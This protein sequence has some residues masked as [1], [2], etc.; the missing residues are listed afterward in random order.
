LASAYPLIL[1]LSRR[2]VVIIGGGKV[3]VRKAG[4]IVA[5]GGKLIRVIA[6][7]VEETM[8]PEVQVVRESFRPDHLNGA[9]LV[10]AATNDPAVNDAVVL[11]CRQ[12]NLLVCRADVSATLPG[13]FSTP[14]LLRKEDLLVAVSAGGSAALAA[15]IRDQLAA[16]LDPRWMRLAALMQR[17]RP[18]LLARAELTQ[19]QR[20]DIFHLLAS[21]QALDV[22]EQRGEEGL[23]AWAER[24]IDQTRS[25]AA[26]ARPSP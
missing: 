14:A 22:L 11:E 10:F 7:A 6:P 26:D 3:A 4:G 18:L 17:I 5:A 1:D 24:M 13:D 19:S 15:R 20:A 12:R 9:A 8:P 23:L 21:D 25:P 2:L 16:A